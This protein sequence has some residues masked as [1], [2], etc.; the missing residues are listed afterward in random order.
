MNKTRRDWSG[1]Y[2]CCR[3]KRDSLT[4]FYSLAT[5]IFVIAIGF[6]GI[7]Y[8][9]GSKTPRIEAIDERQLLRN[10]EDTSRRPIPGSSSGASSSNVPSQPKKQLLINQEDSDDEILGAPMIKPTNSDLIT[11][12]KE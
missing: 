6:Y 8:W 10:H 1:L 4:A 3:E 5:S 12:D 2:K 11:L 7:I 9:V